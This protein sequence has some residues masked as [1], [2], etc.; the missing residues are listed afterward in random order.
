MNRKDKIARAIVP[1]IPQDEYPNCVFIPS[2]NKKAQIW[3]TVGPRGLELHT[4]CPEVRAAIELL[5][6]PTPEPLAVLA[7]RKGYSIQVEGS[8]DWVVALKSLRKY[9][10]ELVPYAFIADT[11]AEAETKARQ[12]LES[13]PDKC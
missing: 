5:Q 11:Y 13:L 6:S 2:R 3:F 4:A 10:S 1:N 12:Y 8:C 7:D 9:N